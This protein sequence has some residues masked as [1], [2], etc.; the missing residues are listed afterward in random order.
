MYFWIVRLA[1]WMP[2]FSSSPRIR[3]APQVALDSAMRR[4]SSM[5]SGA[6]RGR[7]L[8][9]LRDFKRQKRRNPWRCQRRIV[10]GFTSRTASRHRGT[11]RATR[12]SRPRSCDRKAGRLTLRET[13]MSCWR[14]KAFSA[15]SSLRD[16]GRSTASPVTRGRGRVASRM[17]D[18]MRPT[19]AVA[20]ARRRL[21]NLDS[22]GAVWPK[23]AE[24]TSLRVQDS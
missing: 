15:S 5:R 20:A 21:R 2:S 18:L 10:S 13:T 24:S 22:T 9:G 11:N 6:S 16:R 7:G 23:A 1:M 3:S 8:P 17:A 4:M 12:T 19:T 14:R